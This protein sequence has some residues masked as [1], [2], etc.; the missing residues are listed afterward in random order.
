MDLSEE[1][2]QYNVKFFN[3]YDCSP[4]LYKSFIFYFQG[5]EGFDPNKKPHIFLRS[6]FD[7][8]KPSMKKS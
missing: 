7:E 3:Q 1:Y 2:L 5:H 4:L 8:L 6:C